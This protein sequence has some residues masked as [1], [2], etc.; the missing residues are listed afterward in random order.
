MTPTCCR[1]GATSR[2]AHRCCGAP[3]RCRA[4]RG[5]RRPPLERYRRRFPRARPPRPTCGGR[6][7]ST[8][9]AGASSPSQISGW[10]TDSP[11]QGPSTPPTHACSPVWYTPMTAVSGL[12]MQ[13]FVPCIEQWAEAPATPPGTRPTPSRR[14][15]E[16]S[17]GA[18]ISNNRIAARRP[19]PPPCASTRRPPRSLVMDATERLSPSP[20]RRARHASRKRLSSCP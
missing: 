12:T 8:R 2:K 15:S 7:R 11:T 5:P 6:P 3:T 1:G 17:P 13:G 18:E 14:S 19:P 20:A 10:G 9:G 4:G 16:P